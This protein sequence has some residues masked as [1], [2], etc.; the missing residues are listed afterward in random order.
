M[1]KAAEF[2]KYQLILFYVENSKT[3]K[4]ANTEDPDEPSHLDLQCL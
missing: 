2:K 4:K 3:V 1:F